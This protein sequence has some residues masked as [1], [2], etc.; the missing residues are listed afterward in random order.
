MS[1]NQRG[2]TRMASWHNSYTLMQWKCSSSL[3]RPCQRWKSLNLPQYACCTIRTVS[4]LPQK[5][6]LKYFTVMWRECLHNICQRKKFQR[7]SLSNHALIST[8]AVCATRHAKLSTLVRKMWCYEVP[9]WRSEMYWHKLRVNIF[10]LT[11]FL[12]KQIRSSQNNV[13]SVA[14]FAKLRCS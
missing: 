14:K 8:R 12:I 3:L 13:D 11:L 2:R 10:Q 9:F 1:L 5:D 4:D 7:V 6:D